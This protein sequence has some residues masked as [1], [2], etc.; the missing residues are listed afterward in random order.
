MGFHVGSRT[1]DRLHYHSS[2]PGN[3]HTKKLG[4]SRNGYLGLKQT[5]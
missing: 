2:I 5:A 3:P 4:I 1:E